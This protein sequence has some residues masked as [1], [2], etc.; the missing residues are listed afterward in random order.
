M[1]TPKRS[2]LIYRLINE[3][4]NGQL[5]LTSSLNTL[6]LLPMLT[7]S[8]ERLAFLLVVL[9][10]VPSVFQIQ[11]SQAEAA[12]E[13]LTNG[14]FDHGI[15][16]W[17]PYQID[18]GGNYS[19]DHGYLD[20]WIPQTNPVSGMKEHGIGFRQVVDR[21][22]LTFDLTYSLSIRPEVSHRQSFPSSLIPTLIRSRIELF[23]T[24]RDERSVTFLLIYHFLWEA[25]EVREKRPYTA[26]FLKPAETYAWKQFVIDVKK[27]FEKE[28][29][30][31]S[32]YNLERIEV[33]LELAQISV[34]FSTPHALWDDISLIGKCVTETSTPTPTQTFESTTSE[35]TTTQGR[36]T[37]IMPALTFPPEVI[38]WTVGLTSVVAISTAALVY[39]SER[40]R[41]AYPSKPATLRSLGQ[42]PP[43][44]K[45]GLRP[46]RASVAPLSPAVRVQTIEGLMSLDDKVYAYISDRG[47]EISWSQGCRDLGIS[48]DELKASIERL[49]KAGRIE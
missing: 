27:D 16:G 34:P 45:E 46:V 1:H 35:I 43:A 44:T 38:F 32:G 33:F 25:S 11:S 17:V 4:D 15:D 49:K 19:A 28:F 42:K 22:D 40:R 6:E 3:T 2:S 41:R 13:L 20:M 37:P 39:V 10:V 7:F 8:R 14:K 30:P 5:Y 24:T 23:T 12:T 29:G 36:T 47:G 26:H 21:R 9:M 48:I 18:S 31:S